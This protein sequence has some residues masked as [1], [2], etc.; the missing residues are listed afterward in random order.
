MKAPLRNKIIIALLITLY[1]VSGFFREFIFLN[2][3]EQ[4]R[5]TYYHATDSHLADSMKWISGLSYSTLY[6]SKWL[7][8]LLFTI[9][10]AVLAGRIIKKAFGE[11]RFVRITWIA[12]AATF[13]LG[14]LFYLAGSLTGNTETTYDIARFLAGLTETPGMLVILGAFFLALRRN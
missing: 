14:L 7:L 9:F 6:Y 12:Y 10:F 3:N 11:K 1:I 2:I 8:T 5:V 13:V 4:S